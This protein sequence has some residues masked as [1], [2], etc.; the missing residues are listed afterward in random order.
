MK[1]ALILG[2]LISIL[3][4]CA[5][6]EENL[7]TEGRNP[8]S[9]TELETLFEGGLTVSFK[10]TRNSGQV[11]YLTDGKCE[12]KWGSGTD[13]GIYSVRDSMLCAKWTEIRDGK[14]GC[15]K[16]YRVGDNKYMSIN[17]DGTLNTEFSLIQ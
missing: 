2:S 14:E 13:T 12:V 1:K 10:S 5:T 9:Q 7:K 4:N 6:V 15:F 3:I 11:T 17:Q 8:L 16:I